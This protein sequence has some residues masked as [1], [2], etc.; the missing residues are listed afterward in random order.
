MIWKTI[1]ADKNYGMG[2]WYD[3]KVYDIS[4]F[5]FGL[6]RPFAITIWVY[7]ICDNLLHIICNYIALRCL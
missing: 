2:E 3:K 1:T 6:D 7:I 5:G 4:N